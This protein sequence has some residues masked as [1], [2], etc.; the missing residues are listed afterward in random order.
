MC[1]Y[2]KINTDHNYNNAYL[3][4]EIYTFVNLIKE[5]WLGRSTCTSESGLIKMQQEWNI[6]HVSYYPALFQT[7]HQV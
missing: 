3:T 2:K 6:E 5:Q 1:H 4:I 7:D